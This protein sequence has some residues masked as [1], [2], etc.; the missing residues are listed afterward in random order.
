MPDTAY[1][2]VASV[3]GVSGGSSLVY[4]YI[5]PP[6]VTNLCQI[7]CLQNSGGSPADTIT[8]VAVFR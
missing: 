8:H 3:N 7:T 2:V 5:I 1:S 4:P 6:S